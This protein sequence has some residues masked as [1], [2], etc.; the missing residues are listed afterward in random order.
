MVVMGCYVTNPVA[1]YSQ[2]RAVSPATELLQCP[3]TCGLLL[4][5]GHVTQLRKEPSGLEQF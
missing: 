2:D 4:F 1:E 5:P 3:P